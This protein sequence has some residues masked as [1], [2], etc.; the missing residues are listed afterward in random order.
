MIAWTLFYNPMPLTSDLVRLLLVLPLCAG[1]AI[2]YK[3]VRENDL[4]RLFLRIISLF[5][6][7]IVGLVMLGVVMWLIQRYWS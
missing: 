3:T 1:V 4:R 2:V 7:M 6:Y 5:C